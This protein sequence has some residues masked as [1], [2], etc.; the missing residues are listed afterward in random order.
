MSVRWLDELLSAARAD[1]CSTC[2][3]ELDYCRVDVPNRRAVGVSGT[4]Y[5]LVLARL[6]TPGR[7]DECRACTCM[8]GSRHRLK[9]TTCC[10][11][12]CAGVTLAMQRQVA[13]L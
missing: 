8:A 11:A 13:H 5:D 7:F 10:L 2:T 4:C 6:R 9:L 12:G 1:G 3:G